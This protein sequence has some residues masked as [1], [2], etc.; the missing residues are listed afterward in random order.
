MKHFAVLCLLG[1]CLLLPGAAYAGTLDQQQLTDNTN[2]VIR[3]TNTFRVAQT[4]TPALTGALD[5]VDVLVEQYAGGPNG[6][7]TGPITVQI[8]AVVGGQPSGPV[9]GTGSIPL[10]STSPSGRTW[11]SVTI[12]P[13]VA[14]AFGTLYAM[15]LST[16]P[17]GY[18]WG[19]AR[20]GPYPG[21][22]ALLSQNGG[23]FAPDPG[24]G[25]GPQDMA[26]KTYVIGITGVG[27]H[28]ATASRSAHGVVVRWRAD[29]Q[30][31]LLGFNVWRGT[32]PVNHAL[33]PASATGRYS[34]RDRLAPRG[35]AVTYRIEAV[36]A[37][38]SHSWARAVARR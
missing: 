9:L 23:A 14:V 19:G 10:A 31:G 8:Q 4:F 20:P 7:P 12:T 2:F 13:N 26:F 35:R 32:T 27:V 21:G 25:S 18:L 17:G 22:Q 36:R 15:V 1:I 11:E 28:A 5:Q 34:F 37:D 6:A 24:G 16:G 30:L 29:A 3:D 33:I 38:G